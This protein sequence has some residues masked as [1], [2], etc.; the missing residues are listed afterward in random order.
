MKNRLLPIPIHMLP[1]FYAVFS[2]SIIKKKPIKVFSPKS[3]WERK[4]ET[5]NLRSPLTF[6]A[7][8]QSQMMNSSSFLVVVP[9]VPSIVNEKEEVKN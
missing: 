4:F 6:P 2:L 9:V 8:S 1:F 5:P 3:E 7:G